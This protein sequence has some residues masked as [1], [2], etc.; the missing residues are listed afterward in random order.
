MLLSQ[1]KSRDAGFQAFHPVIRQALTW[2]EAQDFSQME[3]GKYDILPDNQMFCL[4]QQAVTAPQTEQRPESHFRYVDIQYLLSGKE[5]IGVCRYQDGFPQDGE[6][7]HERDIVFYRSVG[8]ET[9]ISLLPGMFAVFFPEDIH[10]PC[11][12]ME[13][14]EAIT[15]AVIKINLSLFNRS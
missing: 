5:N 7:S 8:E 12:Q 9:V 3:P 1:A 14:P 13:Q 10:R 2:I 6:A 4:L 11:C 15:K